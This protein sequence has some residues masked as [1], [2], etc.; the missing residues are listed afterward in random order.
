M[1]PLPLQPPVTTSSSFVCQSHAK[2]SGLSIIVANAV[3]Y[4]FCSPLF[5]R[6]DN[7]HTCLSRNLLA[8]MYER[9]LELYTLQR[10]SIHSKSSPPS[11]N[12]FVSFFDNGRMFFLLH[13]TPAANR[14][15]RCSSLLRFLRTLLYSAKCSILLSLTGLDILLFLFVL[16]LKCFF[17]K[18]INC[19]DYELG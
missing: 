18:L 2:G 1:S 7:L 9:L 5:L 16:F 15:G 10:T 4:L 13:L 6:D 12:H 3:S 19:A 17:L 14:L 11:F 8:S